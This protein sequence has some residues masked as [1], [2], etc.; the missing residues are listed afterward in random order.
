MSDTVS[1]LVSHDFQRLRAVLRP[2]CLEAC[3]V[4]GQIEECAS[5]TYEWAQTRYP[6]A[7][8]AVTK[9]LD[10]QRAKIERQFNEWTR[11]IE[12]APPQLERQLTEMTQTLEQRV[13]WTLPQLPE[14]Q[15]ELPEIPTSPELFPLRKEFERALWL[16]DMAEWQDGSQEALTLRMAIAPIEPWR[17]CRAAFSVKP[18]RVVSLCLSLGLLWLYA[19]LPSTSL[20]YRRRQMIEPLLRDIAVAYEGLS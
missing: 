8:W 19:H 4:S 14:L 3:E 18:W 6:L 1:R 11:S 16:L 20:E 15:I 12:E 2:E 5:K 9:W 17:V 10:A 7:R 13:G